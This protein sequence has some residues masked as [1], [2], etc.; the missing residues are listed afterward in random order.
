MLFFKKQ[1]YYESGNKAGTFLARALR[2]HTSANNIAGIKNNIGKLDV[3]SE[4]IAEHFQNFYTK[5]YNLPP[6]HKQ[7]HMVGDRAQII[8]DYLTK[9]GLPKL[10]DIDAD[11]LET[12]ISS[13]E[14][15]Q[16]IKQL[17][18]GKSPGPDGYSAMHYKTFIGI[19]TDPLGAALNSLS[20]ARA[21]TPD[22]LTEHIAV[23]PKPG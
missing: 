16:S 22:F 10:V 23:I 13:S 20:T 4:R 1:I 15:R 17:K 7:P 11:L 8:Q 14:L 2:E 12:P 5:L 3:A 19:L 6:Q 21:V 9:S 18:S